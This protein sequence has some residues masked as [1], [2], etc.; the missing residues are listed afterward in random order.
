MIQWSN[1]YWSWECPRHVHIPLA[2]LDFMPLG[3]KYLE[4]P[5]KCFNL[6]HKTWCMPKT[7]KIMCHNYASGGIK[8]TTVVFSVGFGY[9]LPL[10]E[11]LHRY[12]H[13]SLQ[14]YCRG[15]GGITIIPI[16]HHISL[17]IG[18]R[19]FRA[20]K[21]KEDSIVIVFGTNIV[22]PLLWSNLFWC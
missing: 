17:Y 7:H 22:A 15:S 6:F 13:I 4:A 11:H 18:Q 9:Y 3:C 16:S 20:T 19:I 8:C 5:L 1:W 10:W 14:H 2:Y 21:M 12:H